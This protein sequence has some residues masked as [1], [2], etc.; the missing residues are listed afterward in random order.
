MCTTTIEKK[1]TLTY[2]SH[3]HLHSY[4]PD[5]AFLRV[6]LVRWYTC[7]VS[8]IVSADCL[9]LLIFKYDGV[10]VPV[11]SLHAWY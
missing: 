9:A 11:M 10:N 1:E 6:G 4:G 3:W 2:L 7:S 5:N 8:E